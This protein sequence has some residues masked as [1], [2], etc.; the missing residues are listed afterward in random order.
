MVKKRLF[1]ALVAISA[2]IVVLLVGYSIWIDS[3]ASTSYESLVVTNMALGNG[4]LSI[5]LDSTDSAS[6]FRS[7]NYDIVNHTHSS[8]LFRSGL[9]PVKVHIQDEALSNVHSVYLRDGKSAKLVDIVLPFQK[10]GGVARLPAEGGGTVVQMP[11]GE[12]GILT[13]L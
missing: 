10:E 8:S 5:T 13:W 4:E 3:N 2:V 6:L 1:D 7:Y 11:A 9:W 12:G